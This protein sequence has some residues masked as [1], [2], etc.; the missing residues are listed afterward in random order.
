MNNGVKRKTKR[1]SKKERT[2]QEE[3]VRKRQVCRVVVVQA[4]G[5]GD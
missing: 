2:T 1:V 5:P 4:K 3:R